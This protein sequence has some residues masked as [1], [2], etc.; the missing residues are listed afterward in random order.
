MRQIILDTETTGLE[1]AQGHRI[2]EIGAVELVDRRQTQRHFH[3]YL[4]PDRLIDPGAMQ[5]H[6]ITDES[7][8]GKPRFSDV[9]HEF[10]D[11]VR[12]AEL[13]IHNA[14][15]D[16]AFLDRELTLLG[17]TLPRIADICKVQCSLLLARSIHP[18]QK[19]SLDGL[20]KRY[21]IDNTQ[22]QW[23]GALLDAKILVDVYLAMTGGQALLSLDAAQDNGGV[24]A[25]RRLTANRAP[26]P[27]PRATSDEL[28]AHVRRIDTIDKHS[29][30]LCVW[31]KLDS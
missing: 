30:G 15:F 31:K 5:V 18:G 1:P 23:H 10:I 7:L 28:A 29:A 26:L 4:Q 21:Q 14:A 3:H 20:C 19:N 8:V 6:G 25:I 27:V 11:F 12:G 16:V 17:E 9:A 2:I 24:H 13:I 22:R